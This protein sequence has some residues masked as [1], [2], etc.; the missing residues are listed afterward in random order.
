[1]SQCQAADH[2]EDTWQGRMPLRKW[3]SE[4]LPKTI[5][6]LSIV[7]ETERLIIRHF[8]TSDLVQLYSIMQ[9]PEVMYAWEHGF[10]ERETQEWLD[11]QLHRYHADGYGYFAVVQRDSGRLIGQAGL[12]KNEVKG[13]AAVEIG[14]IFDDVVWGKGFAFEAAS[15]CA[16]LAFGR[17]KLDRLL[18]TIRPENKPSIRLALKLGMHKAGEYVKIYQGKAMPHDIYERGRVNKAEGGEAH[19]I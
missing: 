7:V 6:E 17:F 15:A 16:G 8:Q 4:S 9:K 13:E 19:E 18:A 2:K 3:R 1:M 14:Y 5:D 10:S 11:R 12:V